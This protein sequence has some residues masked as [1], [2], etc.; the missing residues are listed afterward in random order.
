LPSWDP[1]TYTF[2]PYTASLCHD[3]TRYGVGEV[4]TIDNL[5]SEQSKAAVILEQTDVTKN[6]ADVMDVK[7]DV[8]STNSPEPEGPSALV[9]HDLEGKL[10]IS[11]FYTLK[12]RAK[13]AKN[14]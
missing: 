14:L 7:P 12:C 6:G 8:R 1:K 9:S 4:H 5:V 11:K 10:N 3:F 2:P 13:S